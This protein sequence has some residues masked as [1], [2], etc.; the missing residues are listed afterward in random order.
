MTSIIHLDKCSRSCNSFDDLSTRVC[1]ANK[2]KEANVKVF[3]TITNKNE[4]KRILK[5]ISRD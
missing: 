5:H 3:N 2:T 1:V 4:A